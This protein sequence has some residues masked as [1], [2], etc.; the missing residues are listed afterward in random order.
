MGYLNRLFGSIGSVAEDSNVKF[1]NVV[2]A[3]KKYKETIPRKISLINS[4]VIDVAELNNLLAT[5][6]VDLDEEEYSEEELIRDIES[7][8]HNKRLAELKS[9]KYRFGYELSIYLHIYHLLKN[10]YNILL[11]EIRIARRLAAN[12]SDRP[13]LIK[14]FRQQLE[15]EQEIISQIDGYGKFNHLFFDLLKEIHIVERLDAIG[16]RHFNRMVQMFLNEVPQSITYRWVQ[17]VLDALEQREY[18]GIEWP[19]DHP[20]VDYE[21]INSWKFEVLVSKVLV[22]L[23]PGK[24][25]SDHMIQIFVKDFRDG[26]NTRFPTY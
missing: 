20:N 21:F 26:F 9:L 7:I 10:L 6:L 17:G 18:E 8:E 4:A 3:W 12:T 23:K 1:Q 16:K 5:E 22:S 2:S 14:H 19:A 13:N 25:V 15:L 11:S 24:K